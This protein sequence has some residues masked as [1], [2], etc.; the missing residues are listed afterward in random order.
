MEFSRRLVIILFF[1]KPNYIVSS[2]N[3]NQSLEEVSTNEWC[4]SSRTIWPSWPYGRPPLLL[5]G[6]FF[7]MSRNFRRLIIFGCQI[8]LLLLVFVCFGIYWSTLM[9]VKGAS[10]V[11]QRSVATARVVYLRQE[12]VVWNR[13]RFNLIFQSILKIESRGKGG[14]QAS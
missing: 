6:C 11:T 2:F 10:T 8:L 13:F 5:K 4:N 9:W 1:L 7:W 14:P 3:H 12:V